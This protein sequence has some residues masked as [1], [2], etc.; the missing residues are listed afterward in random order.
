V[1]LVVNHLHLREPVTDD[2]QRA[3]REGLQAV[4]DAG[5]LSARLVEVDPTHLILLL[6]FAS[7]ED[8]SRVSREIGSPWMRANNLPL[9]AR[10][11]ERSVGE[12]VASVQY[13]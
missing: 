9:L 3:A 1:H 13:P 11:T 8:A 12:V 2:T 10:D 4:V 6:E 5:G 7:A